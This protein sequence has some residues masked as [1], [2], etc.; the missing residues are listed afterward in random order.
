MKTIHVHTLES[1]AI[2]W[3]LCQLEGCEISRRSQDKS[4]GMQFMFR[5]PDW[6]TV[7][8]ATVLNTGDWTTNMPD[9]LT[10]KAGDDIIDREKI[11]TTW[12]ITDAEGGGYWRAQNLFT[13]VYGT[14][15]ATRRLAGMRCYIEGKHGDTVEVPEELL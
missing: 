7:G 12:A 4:F 2:E 5:K 8:T 14:T 11:E 3:V 9:Y 10:G 1:P 6:R 15:G 13:D